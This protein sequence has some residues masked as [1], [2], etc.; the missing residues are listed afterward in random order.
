[1]IFETLHDS[2]QRGELL[3]VDGGFCH[4]HLRRDG[5]LTIR[6]IIS[7]RTGAGAQM[8]RRLEAA[9]GATSLFAKCP[10]SLPANAWYSRRGFHVER[11]ERTGSGRMLLCW[12]KSLSYA[13]RRPN[14]G[15]LEVIFCAGNNARFGDA[16]C[17]AGLLPGTRDCDKITHR[18]Y[19]MDQ[20]W[21]APDFDAYEAVL[22]KHRPHVAT[23]LDW[24]RRAQLP[25]VMRWAE[26]AACYAQV[27]VIIPKVIG[28]VA[29]LPHTINGKPVRIGYSVPTSHAGPYDQERG[30]VIVPLSEFQAWDGP[31]GVHLLGGSPQAQIHIYKQLGNVRSVDGNMILERSHACQYFAWPPMNKAGNRWFPKLAE[32]GGAAYTRDANLEAFRRSCASVLAAWRDTVQQPMAVAPLPYTMALFDTV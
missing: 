4:W 32:A 15:N 6:E 21:E 10:A 1:M 7:T 26:M 16:A 30:G 22:T 25:E 5:Q 29:Q 24:E 27:V 3:L 19:F 12:R 14:A 31:G 13:V 28:G 18:P 8:L 11:A 17:D 20:N 2:A 23:V 9:P